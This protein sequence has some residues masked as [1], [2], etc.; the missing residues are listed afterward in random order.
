MKDR[1]IES[2]DRTNRNDSCHPFS[3]SRRGFLKATASGLLATGTAAGPVNAAANTDAFALNYILGSPMYGTAPFGEV[4]AQAKMIGASAIDVWPRRHANH[5]EQLDALGHETVQRILAEH[6]VTL[7][8]F[9]RY[10]LGPYRLQTE[11]PVL[12]RFGGKLLVCGAGNTSGDSLKVRVEKFVASMRQ[13]VEAAA[14]HGIGIGIE[15]HGGSL[16]SSPDSIRYFAD[17]IKW[18]NFG[19]AMAPYHLPQD[20]QLIADLIEHLGDKLMFFQAWEHGEGCMKKLPKER[21]M[22]QMPARGPMDFVPIL[23]ALKRIN[24]GGWTEVFM[25]PVPRGIPVRDT[26]EEVTR[27][28]NHS[29]GYLEQCL[30]RINK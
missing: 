23:A 29:R 7:G 8:M 5:R 20:P 17:S 15:N 16:L 12:Q 27:E 10:D 13:H 25:H 18:T 26:T 1:G 22:L 24:Y 2:A 11:M 6:Q 9:T 30:M 4:V 14:E 19:L 28:I 21:E 3:L